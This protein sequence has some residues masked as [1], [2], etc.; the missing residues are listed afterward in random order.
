MPLP[1]GEG[2]FLP[3]SDPKTF[4]TENETLHKAVN[5]RASFKHSNYT[6]AKIERTSGFKK[7][8]DSNLKNRNYVAGD[9]SY[10]PSS[11]DAKV[12]YY[13]YYYFII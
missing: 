9:S 1:K 12:Y 7:Q 8:N 10:L 6:I 11:V 13:H 5:H 3:I 4:V 2:G